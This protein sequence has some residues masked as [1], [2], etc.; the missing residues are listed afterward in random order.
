MLIKFKLPIIL[1]S[2]SFIF[3]LLFLNLDIYSLVILLQLISSNH[4]ALLKRLTYFKRADTWSLCGCYQFLWIISTILQAK[5]ELFSW[6]CPIIP[7]SFSHLLFSK[8]FQH[9]VLMSTCNCNLP[10]CCLEKCTLTAEFAC[11]AV[12]GNAQKMTAHMLFYEVPNNVH[13]LVWQTWICDLI[14]SP[15]QRVSVNIISLSKCSCLAYI[16]KENSITSTQ[17]KRWMI[18]GDCIM[19]CTA[20]CI[21]HILTFLNAT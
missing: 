3:H 10:Q 5:H 21:S 15:W 6:N 13:I 12:Y 2:N 8:L 17:N 19:L 16:Q 20:T 4:K 9:N 1:S 11:R 18:Q 14:W 7:D